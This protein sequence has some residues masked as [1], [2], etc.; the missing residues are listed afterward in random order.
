VLEGQTGTPADIPAA[1][2]RISNN[3]V[4]LLMVGAA[5]VLALG[6]LIYTAFPGN[7][8]YYL[9]VDEFLAQ[10]SA[11]DGRNVRVVGKLVPDTFQ[12]VDGGT[13]AAFAVHDNAEALNA[14][15]DGVLPDIFFNPHSDIVLLGSYDAEGGVFHAS[16]VVVKCPSKFQPLREDEA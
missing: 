7:A 2:G 14:T 5:L 13:Q 1:A 15:Y 16:E 8:Q 9:T 11:Q 10:D 12:R 3:K 6:Y 4:R